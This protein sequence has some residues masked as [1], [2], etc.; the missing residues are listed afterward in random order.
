MDL[1][2]K[3]SF[4]AHLLVVAVVRLCF[5]DSHMPHFHE[6]NAWR[7]F[8]LSSTN[9]HM[10][11]AVRSFWPGIFFDFMQLSNYEYILSECHDKMLNDVM[12]HVI[13]QRSTS[14]LVRGCK[15][16][17]EWHVEG[18]TVAT[19]RQFWVT[20]VMIYQNQINAFLH[21]FLAH[22]LLLFDAIKYRKLSPQTTWLSAPGK[23]WEWIQK[24]EQRVC[25]F[26]GG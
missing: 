24:P 18:V 16:H 11:L 13:G 15:M 25:A 20:Q 3:K 22:Q 6:Q 2:S 9:L 17:L 4:H 14:L 5:P 8:I 26:L 19:L 21:G 12:L 1:A 23:W 7:N 10:I